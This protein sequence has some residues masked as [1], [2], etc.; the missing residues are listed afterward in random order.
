MFQARFREFSGHPLIGEVR[1]VGLIGAAEL[2]ADKEKKS[3]FSTPG[4]V[5]NKVLSICQKNGLICRAIG[6]VIAFCPPLIITEE[7]ID[8]LFEKFR[9]SMDETLDWYMKENIS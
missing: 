5:G 8:E 1:G 2:V 9:R 3:G 6:D 7:Q 4:L